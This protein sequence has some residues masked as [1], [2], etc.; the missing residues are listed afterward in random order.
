MSKLINKLGKSSN[1][2]TLPPALA[3]RFSGQFQL[4]LISLFIG[5]IAAIALDPKT[6]LLPLLIGCSLLIS[7]CAY[8]HSIFLNG[9]T[10]I[11]GVVME[12]SNFLPFLNSRKAD[13]VIIQSAT[14]QIAVPVT[15][16]KQPP[17]I[18]ATLK[19]YVPAAALSYV[20]QEGTTTYSTI[21]GYEIVSLPGQEG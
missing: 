9:Y 21:Y 16:R 7:A 14:S 20:N 10:E 19:V 17:M 15:K 2:P 18:G 11:T 12:H 6:A 1:S 8:K 5:V 13:W 4:G 3:K